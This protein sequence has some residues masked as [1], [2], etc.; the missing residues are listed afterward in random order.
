VLLPKDEI[1]VKQMAV[2]EWSLLGSAKLTE[3]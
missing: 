2:A 1:E 3:R